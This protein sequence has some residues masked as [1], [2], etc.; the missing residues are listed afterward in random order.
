MRGI[1]N[2]ERAFSFK[3]REITPWLF[4]K[5]ISSV[6]G[7]VSEITEMMSLRKWKK[8]KKHRTQCTHGKIRLVRANSLSLL[9]EDKE[10]IMIPETLKQKN[11]RWT[12]VMGENCWSS[13]PIVLI[14]IVRWNVES[15][16]D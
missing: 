15:S 7:K 1:L 8:N 2:Q 10:E 11:G 12:D 16:A 13:F 3:R 5:R 4:A 14:F 9:K 6:Q